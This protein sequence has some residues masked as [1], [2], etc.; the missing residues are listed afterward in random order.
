MIRIGHL[1]IKL[2]QAHANRGPRIAM[3]IEREMAHLSLP[4]FQS[5][6]SI[7]LPNL[8][9]GQKSDRQVAREIVNGI[10]RSMAQ[11]PVSSIP[12]EQGAGGE[13]A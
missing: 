1:R 11:N 2:P 5:C 6:S 13:Y 4:G 7:R 9:L 12:K 8:R 10:E 3:M